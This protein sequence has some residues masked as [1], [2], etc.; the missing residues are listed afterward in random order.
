MATLMFDIPGFRVQF[1]F[2]SDE[3]QWPDARLQGCWDS[4]TCHISPVENQCIS[5]SCLRRAV[6]LMT[7]HLCQLSNVALAGDSGGVVNSASIGRVSVSI[8]PPPFG[9]DQW[10][11]W[12][13]QTVYGQEL[14][15][16]LS[17]KKVGGQFIGGRPEKSAFRKVFGIF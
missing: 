16:L 13:N 8:T 5:G 7:A 17:V 12:L 14:E 3:T 6:N 9:G 11:W 4:A 2:F 1:P 10:S 15:A